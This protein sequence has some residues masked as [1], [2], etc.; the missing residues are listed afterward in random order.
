LST[1]DEPAFEIVV[2]D[3]AGGRRL[4]S[5]DEDLAESIAALAARRIDQV[6]LTTERYARRVHDEEMQKLAAEAEL[7]ALRAQINPHFLFNA[8]T[9]IGYLI[10]DSPAK[11]LDT[12]MR[13]TSLL[14]GVLRPDGEWTTLGRELELVEH[15]LDIERARFEERLRVSIEVPRGLRHLAIPALLVQPLVENAVKHGVAPSVRGGD[16]RVT[17]A[18]TADTPHAAMRITVWNTGAPLAATARPDGVGL[19]N[20]EQRLRGHFGDQATLRV[21]RDSAG[22][23]VAS[24]ELP[25]R[26]ERTHDTGLETAARAAGRR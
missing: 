6:R 7:K 4:L 23:T 1:T 16:V 15:Y 21:M 12:L 2:A 13:L 14:R 9:T 26:Q 24:I 5:D 10:D 22:A 11:A 25:V 17:A 18:L 20:V 8:L 3:L 19:A